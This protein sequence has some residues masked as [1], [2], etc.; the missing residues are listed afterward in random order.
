MNNNTK[1]LISLDNTGHTYI[2][3]EIKSKD[4]HS[5]I[6]RQYIDESQNNTYKEIEKITNSKCQV[7]KNCNIN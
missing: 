7:F 4:G 6:Q 3:N 2:I 5:S 1:F